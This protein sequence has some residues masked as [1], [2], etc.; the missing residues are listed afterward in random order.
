M[1][2]LPEDPASQMDSPGMGIELPA[3]NPLLD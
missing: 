3:Y 2:D 1:Q